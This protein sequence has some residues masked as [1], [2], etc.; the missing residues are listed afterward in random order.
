MNQKETL[1]R[2]KA[3]VGEYKKG[4]KIAM[5]I[6]YYKITKGG[7]YFILREHKVKLREK[8]LTRKR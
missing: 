8:H 6:D 1:K 2:Q 5:L 4:A 3:I 7:L